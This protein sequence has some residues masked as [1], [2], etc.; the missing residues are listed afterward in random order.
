MRSVGSILSRHRFTIVDF[1]FI[2]PGV[3]RAYVWNR[4]NFVDPPSRSFVVLS[5]WLETMHEVVHYFCSV[6]LVLFDILT[7]SCSGLQNSLFFCSFLFYFTHWT[8][9][10]PVEDLVRE[11]WLFTTQN[12]YQFWY[13]VSIYRRRKSYFCFCFSYDFLVVQQNDPTFNVR[14][15]VQSYFRSAHYSFPIC[16]FKLECWRIQGQRE[17]IHNQISSNYFFP[18]P[19]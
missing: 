5:S 16:L 19:F 1:I 10:V 12:F 11:V 3:L 15:A 13:R 8:G 17:C 4:W 2:I 7:I 18:F 9:V 6:L 14:N